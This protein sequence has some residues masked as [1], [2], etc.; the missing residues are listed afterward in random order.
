MG[1]W[2][3]YKYLSFHTCTKVKYMG[4]WKSRKW[5]K[6]IR[7]L[8]DGDNVL[9]FMTEGELVKGEYGDQVLFEVADIIDVNGKKDLS[10]TKKLYIGNLSLLEDMKAIP[11]FIGHKIL[12]N[13]TGEGNDTRYTVKDLGM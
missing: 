10:D 2:D 5:K 8:D 12:I 4:D 6:E 13:K 1:T 7:K 3:S 11:K 9:V